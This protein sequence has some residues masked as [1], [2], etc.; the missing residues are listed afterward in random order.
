MIQTPNEFLFVGPRKVIQTTIKYKRSFQKLRLST[1]WASHLAL[2]NATE[3]AQRW[4]AFHMLWQLRHL[5]C[6]SFWFLLETMGE[7]SR[8]IVELY[9]ELSDP[10]ESMVHIFQ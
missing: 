9:V 6:P 10:E 7:V 5:P 2:D 8:N 3:V 4:S 1:Q